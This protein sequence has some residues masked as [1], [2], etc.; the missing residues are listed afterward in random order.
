MINS[1]I[2][3]IGMSVI[4]TLISIGVYLGVMSEDSTDIMSAQLEWKIGVHRNATYSVQGQINPTLLM[5]LRFEIHEKS[6]DS[7]DD[8][9]Y[10]VDEQ[11][12]RVWWKNNAEEDDWHLVSSDIYMNIPLSANISSATSTSLTTYD[13]ETQ[14]L[15]ISGFDEPL[16]VISISSTPI[17]EWWEPEV[18][19]EVESMPEINSRRQL[20][21]SSTEYAELIRD[22]D[23]SYYADRHSVSD[24]ITNENAFC[25]YD[26]IDSSTCRITFRGSD[27]GEDW[28]SNFDMSEE[29]FMNFKFHGGFVDEFNKLLAVEEG[30]VNKFEE[31]LT[32][33]G[34]KK[35]QLVGHSLGGAIAD[36]ASMWI[37]ANYPSID[38]EIFTAGQPRPLLSDSIS[39]LSSTQ[40]SKKKYRVAADGDLVTGVPYPWM[41]FSH[42]PYGCVYHCYFYLTWRGWE[43]ECA[44]Y[45][46]EEKNHDNFGYLKPWN[47]RISEYTK[48]NEA[49]SVVGC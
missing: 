34:G 38:Y 32:R 42:M 5:G 24:T 12:V 37:S 44:A 22:M 23:D 45:R 36:V 30:G 10:V 11:N 41:G 40:L 17:A 21:E 15:H 16:S 18:T 2:L 26:D 1:K 49:Y 19:D 31:F 25:F 43:E 35:L 29:L 14:Q 28:A 9:L 27:D 46:A 47:H 4:I 8:W 39:S 7:L 20:V 13:P 48:F 33:C 3:L 6:L